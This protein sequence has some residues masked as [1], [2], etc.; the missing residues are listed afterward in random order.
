MSRPSTAESALD[1]H[2]EHAIRALLVAYGTSI[3]Q[4]NW[5]RFRSCFS[6]DCHADYGQF[7]TWQGADAITSYMEQAHRDLGPTLHRI[8]N[9][10]CVIEDS[11]VRSR[12]YVD[13]LLMPATEGG[14]IHRGIGFYDDQ[15][16]HEAS[17]WKI[18]R[19][20]FTPVLIN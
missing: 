8:T 10:E 9:M 6:N 2:D 20:N 4:R 13:A 11:F 1:M 17:G 19:R 12:C 14:P 5:E 3:D 18:A 7:G 16:A 15:L